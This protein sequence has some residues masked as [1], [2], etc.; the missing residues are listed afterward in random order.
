LIPILEAVGPEE[1]WRRSASAPAPGRSFWR[2][3]LPNVKWGLLYGII[4]CNARAMGEFGRRLCR[5]RTHRGQTTPCRCVSSGCSRN[6]SRRRPFAL[7][8]LLT[9]LA[10][11]TLLI[12]NALER[13]SRPI[14]PRG[15]S[16][17]RI[18]VEKWPRNRLVPALAAEPQRADGAR[19]PCLGRGSGKTTLL[20]ILAGLEIPDA[21]SVHRQRRPTLPAGCP[22]ARVGFV[23]PALALFRH[24][25]VFENIAFHCGCAAAAET[26]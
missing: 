9:S 8:S 16:E 26:T 5:L 12:Q 2:V 3:T 11:I 17:M 1:S 7:A 18:R 24:M 21:G 15:G 25:T 20:R 4:L 13:K 19:A 10:L 14:S 6:T 23:F 22:P